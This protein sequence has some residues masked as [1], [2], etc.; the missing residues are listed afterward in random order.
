MAIVAIILIIIAIYRNFLPKPY[1]FVSDESGTSV[2]NFDRLQ[3]RRLIRSI[4]ARHI[5][6]GSETGMAEF[7]GTDFVFGKGSLLIT[8]TSAAHTI[9]VNN[10]PL[11]GSAYVVDGTWI[12]ATGKLFRFTKE[13][14]YPD[15]SS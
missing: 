6:S 10:H 11:V 8:A 14:T 4:F 13:R 15:H 9:R 7:V 1:G 12:G 2:L 3:K 5:V